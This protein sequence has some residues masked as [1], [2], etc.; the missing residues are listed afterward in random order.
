MAQWLTG[1]RKVPVF[2]G[3]AREFTALR[4]LLGK[5]KTQPIDGILTALWQQSVL[6]EKC[7]FIRLRDAKNALHGNRWRCCLCRFPEQTVS[8]TFTRLRTRHNHYLQ[9]TR[10]E[11]TFLSTGQMNAPLTFQ[12]VLNKPSH[13]FEEIFHLHGFSVKPG[14]EIQ[15]GHATLRTVYIGMPSLSENVWGATPDDLW[16]PQYHG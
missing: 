16:T 9:L 1:A 13:Q 7:D 4:E 14:A 3:L 6:S 8:E 2:S 11:D 10:T 15:T 5:D 12:L